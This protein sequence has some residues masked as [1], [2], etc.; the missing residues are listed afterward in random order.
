MSN[1]NKG[2]TMTKFQRELEELIKLRYNSDT[3]VAHVRADNL[4][5]D[6]LEQLGEDAIVKAFHDIKKWYA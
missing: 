1:F 4:L 2:P 6:I 5:C 3:E